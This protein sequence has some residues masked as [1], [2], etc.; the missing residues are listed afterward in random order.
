MFNQFRRKT[1]RTTNSN[2]VFF[3]EILFIL[4][5]YEN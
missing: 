3:L 4:F 5:M 1:A 2:E